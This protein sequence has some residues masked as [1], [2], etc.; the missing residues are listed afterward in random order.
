MDRALASGAKDCAFK[1]RQAHQPSIIPIDVRVWILKVGCV[2]SLL[3]ESNKGKKLYTGFTV[4]LRR[5]L[6]KD[7]RKSTT[8]TKNRRPFKLLYYETYLLEKVER[9]CE[10]YL[11]TS[12]SKRVINY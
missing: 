6:K 4:N 8:F 10:K 9:A 5:R 3:F 2:L 12:M 1:S 7:N 11:K